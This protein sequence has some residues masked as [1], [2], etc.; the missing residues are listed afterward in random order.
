M[1]QLFLMF[2]LLF[3]ALTAATGCAKRYVDVRGEKFEMIS[4]SEEKELAQNARLALKTIEKKPPPGDYKHIEPTAPEMR[5][6]YSGDRYGR[7]IVR[8]QF[9]R[10]EAGVDYEG[11]LMTKFM[12]STVYTKEKQPEV[13]DFT[14]RKPRRSVLPN[15]RVRTRK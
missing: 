12:V 11:E 5:F 7:A 2:L 9:P 10:Y 6:I 14:R 1:K 3:F 8:W 15:K 13:V 4:E